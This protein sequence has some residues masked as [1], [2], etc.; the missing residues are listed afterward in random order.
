MLLLYSHISYCNLVIHTVDLNIFTLSSTVILTTTSRDQES[1]ESPALDVSADLRLSGNKVD[2]RGPLQL[3]T[4]HAPFE[5]CLD[6][7]QQ[8]HQACHGAQSRHCC[9]VL[10]VSSVLLYYLDHI[11]DV[12]LHPVY[13]NEEPALDVQGPPTTSSTTSVWMASSRML[14]WYLPLSSSGPKVGLGGGVKGTLFR[15]RIQN[16]AQL[17]RVGGWW[18]APVV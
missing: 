3:I 5:H 18:L 10:C 2:K 11:T 13:S 1:D 6:A 14:S 17:R 8:H 12:K 16:Q 9:D 4:P 7:R 15:V